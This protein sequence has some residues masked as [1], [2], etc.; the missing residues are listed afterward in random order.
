MPQPTNKLTATAARNAKPRDKTYRLAD[1][2]GMYLEVT[3]KGG[4]YWRLKYRIDGKEKRL[5]LGVFPETSLAQARE[6][7]DEARR[8]LAQ[9]IDPGA[10]KR[11]EQRQRKIAAANTLEAIAEEW[12][13]EVHKNKV[14]PDHYRHDRRRLEL[15]LLPT[16]GREPLAEMSAADLLDCL[17]KIEKQGK[18]E[19]AKRVR[20]LASLIFRYAIATERADRDPAAD[21]KGA[22]RSPSIRHHPAITDP[23]EIAKLMRAVYAYSGEPATL[24]ALKLSAMVFVRPGELRQAEWQTVDLEA[25]TWSF[26]PSKNAPPLIVPLPS[27]AVEILADLHDL[28]GRGRYVFP[29]ARSAARPMSENAITAALA[30]MGYKGRMTAHGF[31]AMARTVLEER[32]G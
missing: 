14:V 8:H 31:R 1:G 7:R 32:L 10:A 21:L 27:Q 22:L 13:E 16:L 2:G 25:G 17:R 30:G 20:T 4:R 24:A 11:A 28:T 15:H 6:A 12:L 5:A 26:T 3:P 29:G 9:G 23:E 18:L 19:T